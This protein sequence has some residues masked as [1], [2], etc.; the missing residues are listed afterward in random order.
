[1]ALVAQPQNVFFEDIEEINDRELIRATNHA[2]ETGSLTPII[3]EE[4]KCLIQSRRLSL[5]QDEL[6]VTFT[7]QSVPEVINAGYCE[8]QAINF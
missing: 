7:T 8:C 5:G 6:Q 3:K 2:L 1:M 4:L